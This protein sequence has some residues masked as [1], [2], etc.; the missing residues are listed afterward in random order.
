MGTG[1]FERPEP[2]RASSHSSTSP[3]SSGSWDGLLP[4][5]PPETGRGHCLPCSLP[6]D[7]QRIVNDELTRG[8][9]LHHLSKKFAIS[10]ESLRIHRDQHLTAKW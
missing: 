8:T 6:L 3:R 5:S 9:S 10:R 1:P 7:R 4:A 2:V